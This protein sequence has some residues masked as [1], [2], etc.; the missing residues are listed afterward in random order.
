MFNLKAYWD[1]KACLHAYQVSAQSEYFKLF[2][3]ETDFIVLL[4]CGKSINWFVLRAPR[5]DLG[6]RTK[7]EIEI[8]L[9]LKCKRRDQSNGETVSYGWSVKQPYRTYLNIAA[10]AQRWC[11]RQASYEKVLPFPWIFFTNKYS[12]MMPLLLNLDHEQCNIPCYFY[13]RNIA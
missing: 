5:I 6:P 7:F 9:K 4:G 2:Q 13:C 11:M 10:N 3:N 1:C 8:S 12:F